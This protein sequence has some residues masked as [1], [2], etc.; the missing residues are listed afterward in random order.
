M[1]NSDLFFLILNL[2]IIIMAGVYFFMFAQ[3]A[4]EMM[5]PDVVVGEILL[6]GCNVWLWASTIARDVELKKEIKELRSERNEQN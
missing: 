2:G 3:W 4:E 5:D 6:F 1:K